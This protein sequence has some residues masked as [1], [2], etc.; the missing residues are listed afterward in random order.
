MWMDKFVH[1]CLAQSSALFDLTC[2]IKLTKTRWPRQ[3]VPS[4]ALFCPVLVFSHWAPHDTYPDIGFPPNLPGLGVYVWNGLPGIT[5]KIPYSWL[6][7]RL[8]AAGERTNCRRFQ[9][10]RW[11]WSAAWPGT[12][13]LHKHCRLATASWQLRSGAIDLRCPCWLATPSSWDSKWYARRVCGG[14]PA[15]YVYIYSTPTTI[16]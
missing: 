5:R 12:Q 9:P 3:H 13:R 2:R 8:S 7:W 1:I 14:V 6:I 10:S 15:V 16:S 4:P 11:R